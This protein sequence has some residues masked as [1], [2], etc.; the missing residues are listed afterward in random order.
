[1]LQ[2]G[3]DGK[4]VASLRR[5]ARMSFAQIGA[6][7]GL[8]ASAVKRRVDRLESSGVILGYRAV[9]DPAVDGVGVEAFVELSCRNTTLPVDVAGIVDSLPQVVG[10]CTVT[11]EADALLTIRARDMGELEETIATIRSDP[12]T[13][14]TRTV[15]VL[16]RLFGS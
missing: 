6:E 4:I 5:N 12:R 11:G 3:I 14:R 13:D 16:T 15:V 2:D 10:A 9:V 1:M 8:S 7:V